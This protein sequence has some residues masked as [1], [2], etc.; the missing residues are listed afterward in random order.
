MNKALNKLLNKS[1]CVCLD[2]VKIPYRV[3]IRIRGILTYDED[4]KCFIVET[5]D[6]EVGFKESSVETINQDFIHLKHVR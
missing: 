4:Y 5:N 6:G 2:D 1:V 3:S